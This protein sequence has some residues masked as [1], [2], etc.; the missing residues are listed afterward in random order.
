MKKEVIIKY[1]DSRV[2]ELLK[3]LSA[4][5]GFT[6]SEKESDV[7]KGPNMNKIESKSVGFV[8]KWAG[9]LRKTDTDNSRYDYLT[10]K[11]K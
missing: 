3:S 1:E 7:V 11:Y 5:L 8:N 2:L 6:I 4:Y 10:E 9:F